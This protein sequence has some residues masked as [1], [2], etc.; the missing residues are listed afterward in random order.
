MLQISF[1]SFQETHAKHSSRTV[2]GERESS[3]S[4]V[5]R[6]CIWERLHLFF[7]SYLR[8]GFW[9]EKQLFFKLG[10]YPACKK[11]KKMELLAQTERFM[12]YS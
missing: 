7:I 9:L 8:T 5:R 12:S 10:R 2:E 11:K 3:E 1:K 4:A 6:M